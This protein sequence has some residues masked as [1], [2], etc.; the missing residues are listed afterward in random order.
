MCGHDQTQLTR[1]TFCGMLGAWWCKITC[2][3]PA[4]VLVYPQAIWVETEGL[5]IAQDHGMPEERYAWDA[6]SL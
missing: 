5:I 3:N 1:H 4:A 2:N 6:V